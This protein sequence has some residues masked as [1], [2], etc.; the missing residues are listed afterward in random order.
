MTSPVEDPQSR[1]TF[2]NYV[3]YSGI[4]FQM[5]A[6]IGVFAFIGYKIDEHRQSKQPLITAGLSLIGVVVAFY[7]VIRSLKT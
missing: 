5:L 1:K 3:K 6:I 7:Q 4:V 2:N